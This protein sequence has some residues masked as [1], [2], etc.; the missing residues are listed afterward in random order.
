MVRPEAKL[1]SKSL[2]MACI[3]Q[4]L[5]S[6]RNRKMQRHRLNGLTGDCID[7]GQA[8]VVGFTALASH[9]ESMTVSLL[10]DGQDFSNI[11]SKEIQNVA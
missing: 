9:A 10:S 1:A 6:V 2:K 5:C 7:T 4:L 11:A 8:T 3:S